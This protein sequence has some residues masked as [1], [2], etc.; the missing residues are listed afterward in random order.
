MAT[1]PRPVVRV[2]YVVDHLKI[3]GAQTHL[4]QL[5]SRLDRRRFQPMVCAL[6]A[7]GELCRTIESMGVPV[8]DGGL[9]RTL[10]G[11][12]GARVLARLTGLFR[13]ERV[14]V[15]HAYLFH[16][17]VL[18]PIAGR[19]A[20]VPAIIASKRSLDRYPSR[21][22]LWA[23]RFG[24]RLAHRV[25][26]NAEAIGRF[27]GAEE[28]CPH[29]KMVLIPNG[30]REDALAPP[31]DGS[32]KRRE[33]GLPLD[34]PVVGAVSRLAWKKAI[35]HLVQAT[36]RILEAA[37]SARVVIAGDGPLRGEL[38]AQAVALGVRDR[39]LF[40]GSRDDSVE[41]MAA[42]DV[43][44]LPSV[45]EGMSNALIEAMAV[46]RPVVATDVGGNPEVVVDGET[47][48]LVPKAAPDHLA[49][50]IVKL[51][52]APEMAAEMGAAG[53]RRVVQH[54]RV[55]AMARQIEAMYDALLREK[56]A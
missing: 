39:V 15:A 27:V 49:A 29:A 3:G 20:G 36:P 37:P 22:P 1:A 51:L 45:V 35:D 18:A 25:M 33:L 11:V 40:L 54:Y 8:F 9:G 24:N 56:A 30:V 21:L 23:C 46:G 17:N 44:V 48:I 50:A 55:E 2:M 16:P 12:G 31:A 10:M 42:F 32:A 26:V 4:V 43:F 53:R 34:A 47:G 13:R 6:K 52:G 14:D 5:L 7:Q 41:L 19:L 28:G 38:E